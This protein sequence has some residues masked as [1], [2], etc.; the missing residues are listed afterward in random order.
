MSS[1]SQLSG[2]GRHLR[3]VSKGFS[4][5]PLLARLCST[6]SPGD[7]VD[8]A[9]FALRTPV[10]RPKQVPTELIQFASMVANKKPKSVLEIGTSLGGTLFVLCRLADPSAILISLDLPGGKFG[11]GY[12]WFQ[13][14]LFHHFPSRGQRLHLIRDDSHKLEVWER[15][16][17]IL[18]NQKLDLLFID[19]DHTY[20][21]VRTDFE[22]YSPLVRTGGMIVFHDIVQHPADLECGVS[23]FW[24]EIKARYRHEE[25]IEN[26][27]QGWAGIGVLFK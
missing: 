24:N 17:D 6:E 23:Y 18:H 1:S 27:N 8:V 10:I 3:H 21:G 5:F 2:V 12:R 7:P 19:G 15:V 20:Q 4:L 16:A 11:G 25:I 26:S 14:L 22:M 9:K 13:A